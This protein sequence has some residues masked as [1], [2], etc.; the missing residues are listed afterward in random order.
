MKVVTI[1]NPK[2]GVAKTETAVFLAYELAER[3]YKVCFM[4][5]YYLP[6]DLSC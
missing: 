3:G 2:G 1:L 6:D 5:E 4:A